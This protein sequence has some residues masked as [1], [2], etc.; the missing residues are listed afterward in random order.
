M[1]RRRRVYGVPEDVTNRIALG[2]LAFFAV[3]CA[4]YGVVWVWGRL[5]G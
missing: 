5:I 4:G 3:V 2:F 1:S